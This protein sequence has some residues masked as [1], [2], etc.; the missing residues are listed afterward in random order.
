MEKEDDIVVFGKYDSPVEANIVK[1]VLETNGVIAGVMGD[2]TANALLQGL[3]QGTMRVV[4]FRKDL[5]KAKQIMDVT[6]IN[7]FD[8]D[9]ESDQE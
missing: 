4:V 9:G 6:I 8:D 2:A 5:E 7:S 1:G 3:S